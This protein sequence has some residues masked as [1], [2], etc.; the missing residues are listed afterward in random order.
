MRAAVGNLPAFA[1]A[2]AQDTLELERMFPDHPVAIYMCL[3]N[4]Y[5]VMRDS[6]WSQV[7]DGVRSYHFLSRHT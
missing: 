4:A 6:F 5:I 3:S 2:V 7:A 1:I